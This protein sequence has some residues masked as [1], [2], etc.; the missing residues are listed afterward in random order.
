MIAHASVAE[1]VI[2]LIA[3]LAAI[4]VY[5]AAWLRTGGSNWRLASWCGGVGMVLIAT[6]PPIESLALERFSGHMIQHL[7]MIVVAAPL[8]VLAAPV[9]T[10]LTAWPSLR[11]TSPTER[12]V[13]SW[14]HRW[15]PIVA[16]M[17]FIVVLFVT[18]LTGIYDLALDNRLV[19]DV[20]HIAYLSSAVALWA[21]VRGVGRSAAVTRVGSVFAVIAGTAMLGIVLLTA[22]APLVPTYAEQL[23]DTAAVD[24]QRVAAS[25]MWVSGMAMT[26][27]LLLLAVWR[28]AT[29]EERIAVAAERL[30]RAPRSS[31]PR[32]SSDAE[33]A[34]DVLAR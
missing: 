5:G 32:S 13:A 15:A 14:W 28:W 6:S 3:G 17:S 31:V 21:A 16:P 33:S 25:I 10:I 24:D 8:L 18:H 19:H 2:V 23:G 27:P 9:T 1:H 7:L 20:E 29:T 22:S 30:E 34:S 12:Q 26:L 11:R 4:A